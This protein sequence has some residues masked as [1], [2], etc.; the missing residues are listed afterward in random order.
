MKV[1]FIVNPLATLKTYKDSSFAMMREAQARGHELYALTQEDLVLHQGRVLGHAKRLTLTEKPAAWYRLGGAEAV[2]LARF[3]AVLMRADPPF[4]ME[5]VYSTYLLE[6]AEA[7]GA[8]VFNRPGAVRDY[9]EKLSIARFPEFTVDFTVTRQIALIVKFL[10]RHKDIIVKPL[11]GMGGA[12]VFRLRRDDPN[13]MSILETATRRGT[14]TIMAQRYIPE[15]VKGDKRIL[16]IDGQ[17]VPSCLARIPKAGE[18]RAN[19]AAGATGV[20]QKLSARD[21]QIAQALGPKLRDAG[22]MLAGLDVIGDYLTEINVTSPT[23]FREITEQTG[24]NV[25]GMMLDAL[26]QATGGRKKRKSA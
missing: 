4:D 26:E 2:P 5:Y 15:V 10:S 21:R 19:L 12:G 14:R 6:L 3:D 8:R 1:A 24:F 13:S 11:D 23:G 7:E 20:A 9:N 16:L 25:A 18:L 17:A 22:L